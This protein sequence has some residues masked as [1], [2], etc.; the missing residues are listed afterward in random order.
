MNRTLILFLCL[1]AVLSPL[2]GC[3]QKTAPST[4]PK[5]EVITKTSPPLT[6]PPPVPPGEIAP[7]PRIAPRYTVNDDGAKKVDA[8]LSKMSL[9]EKAD[10][11]RGTPKGTADSMNWKDIFRQPDDEKNRIRG[12]LFRDGPRGLNLEARCLEG[13]ECFSTAFPVEI[14]RGATFD[15]E[16]E[17]RIGRAAADETL[18]AGNTMLL[19][20]SVNILRHPAWGR[21]Q[22]SYGEDAFLLGKMG[23]AFVSGAQEYLPACVKHF[24]AN[25]VENE[26]RD[27]NAVMDEQTLHE[28]YGAAYE[29]VIRESG[30]SCVMASYNKVNGVNAAENGPVLTDLLRKEFGFQGFVISDWWALANPFKV[31]LA[32]AKYISAAKKS[33]EAGLDQEMPWSLNYEYLEAAVET[34]QLHPAYIDRAARRVLTEKVRFHVADMDT[35]P[36]LRKPKTRL[37]DRGSIE[38]NEAHIEL[39]Y[40]TAV[41]SMV[42]L[43][44]EKRTLPIN[45]KKVKTVAVLGA[46]VPYEQ[47]KW[48]DRPS[49]KI[50]FS[51]DVTIGDFGSSRVAV[52][53]AKSIGPFEGI[54]R[55]A[56]DNVRVVRGNTVAAAKDADFVVV[57]AGLTPGDE[58]EEYTGAGDRKSF[59]LDDK[60][61]GTPQ[62]DLIEAAAALGKPMVL[63]LVG[64]SVIDIPALDKIPSVVMSWYG[65][66]HG[67]RA[68]G[69]LIFSK[70]NFSGKLP[71]TWPNVWEELPTFDPGVPHPVQMDYYLGYRY[72]DKQNIKPRWPFGHGLS[73]TDF[74]LKN[75]E[76]TGRDISKQGT[77]PVNVDVKNTGRTAG[78]EILFLFASYPETKARRSVKELKGFQRVALLPGETK[79]VTF[80]VDIS[81]LR[82]WNSDKNA[83]EAASGPVQ[84]H[85]GT[86]AANLPLT[87]TLTVVPS[88]ASDP[89]SL[90]IRFLKSLAHS[91]P[92]AP[93]FAPT[94]A[95]IYHRDD[96]C[97]GS[98][99]GTAKTLPSAKIDETISLEV[100]DD[101]KGWTCKPKKPKRR[102]LQFSLKEQIKDWDRFD[103]ETNDKDPHISFISGRAETAYIKIH[104]AD[105]ETGPKIV[106][107]EY[108][109]EDPG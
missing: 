28:V 64:G 16:L 95:L 61:K 74:T 53:P 81:S 29:T 30:V 91:A 33:L 15:T 106:K 71:F 4:P 38:G 58:G 68:L 57:I 88:K 27:S 98:T 43:K 100:Q 24:I 51:K 1:C 12:F 47:R 78:D 109:E 37:N 31:D 75:L 86:D 2:A 26:R 39:A 21:A 87:G 92:L 73:Y 108:R 52:D 70:A 105:T 59:A 76:V 25:N 41:K 55:A 80:P 32:P 13:N 60:I 7:N 89:A 102:T 50:D 49:G 17:V 96:R 8:L 18:A 22:E 83:W 54:Q 42:L 40:E 97:D 99:D 20:P 34:G 14:A 101:G 79:Q 107:L 9:K 36:G 11:L 103:I 82:Y 69:D 104:T 19:A 62:K 67:G 66:I 46:E 77:V 63:V 3:G 84:L 94:W 56:G 72:Y 5:T 90:S 44:N 65:G 35:P 6:L 45:S 85:V 23:A 10:Q 48:A 93:L